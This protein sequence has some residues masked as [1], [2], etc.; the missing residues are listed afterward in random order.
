MNLVSFATSHH[1]F[2]SFRILEIHKV[3]QFKH[4]NVFEIVCSRFLGCC[5]LKSF[6]SLSVND[7]LTCTLLRM[8]TSRVTK[9]YP[10]FDDG[11]MSKTSKFIHFLISICFL[12]LT[13]KDDKILFSKCKTCIYI[14]MTICWF[15]II[16]MV[17]FMTGVDGVTA[18][19]NKEVILEPD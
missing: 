3:L 6:G 9:V 11:S 18:A 8:K 17:T 12:S 1:I 4:I 16:S 5:M 2:P 7:H 10:N 19:Y 15:S 14:L 13:Q